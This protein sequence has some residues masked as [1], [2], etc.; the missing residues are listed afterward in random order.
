MSRSLWCGVAAGVLSVVLVSG[1]A[2]A[3]GRRQCS[4]L[5]PLPAHTT[6]L[7][8]QA[9]YQSFSYEPGNVGPAPVVST[10][11]SRVH[12]HNVAAESYL[13]ADRKAKGIYH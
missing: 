2:E 6:A 13:R 12:R 10:P 7:A 3:G 9:D 11:A 5:T 4:C 1:M 8:P